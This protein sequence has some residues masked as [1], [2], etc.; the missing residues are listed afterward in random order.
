MA[1]GRIVTVDPE[2]SPLWSQL[3][4]RV[5]S[6]V[7]HSP[8]WM[9][10]IRETY[11]FEIAALVMLDGNEEPRA[12]LP[13]ARVSDIFGERL[14]SLPFSDYCDP[15]VDSDSEWT[16]LIDRLIAERHAI[17]VRCVHNDV[18]LGDERFPLVNR[19]K[20]HG[21][22]LRPDVE[23]LWEGLDSAARRAVRKAQKEG[24]T[25]RLADGEDDLRAFYQMHLE[26]RKYKY[27]LLAQ[28]YSFLENIWRHLVQSG[29]GA[30]LLAVHDGEPV[31]GALL[32]EWKNKLYYKFNAS[33]HTHLSVRPNDALMWEAI[34]FGKG[35]GLAYYDFGLSDWDQDELVRYKRKYAR[36]EKT[37]SF[38]RHVPEEG[39]PAHASEFKGVLTQLTDLLTQDDVPDEVTAL[40][41]DS[42]YRFFT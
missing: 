13:F 11:G 23:E 19:A 34:R 29:A 36:D 1:T 25:V 26:V 37:I 24:V 4:R 21:L 35:R 32:L 8:A 3:V 10:V 27:R 39:V 28:P 12:G 18:P 33:R 20:W 30:L 9:R 42:L 40:A 41:G 16:S 38:L 31:G 15:L 5:D 22:D 7:F 14:V 6:D 2:T 17:S